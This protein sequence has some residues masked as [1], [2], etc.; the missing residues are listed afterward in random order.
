MAA[1]GSAV[2]VSMT[3]ISRFRLARFV[4]AELRDRGHDVCPRCGYLRT[5]LD[6]SAPCPECGTLPTT[7]VV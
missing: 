6:E 5:G 1:L 4:Y 7:N 3:L 2:G